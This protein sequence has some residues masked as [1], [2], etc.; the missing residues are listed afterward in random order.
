LAR[1]TG[2]LAGSERGREE[3]EGKIK[4]YTCRATPALSA[5]KSRT[6]EKEWGVR[7]MKTYS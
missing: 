3:A 1:V 2:L 7:L 5:E 6:R 4:N